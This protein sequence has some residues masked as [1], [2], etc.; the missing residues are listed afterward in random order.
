MNKRAAGIGYGFILGAGIGLV[1]GV[2]TRNLWIW[3][4]GGAVVGLLIG[5]LVSTFF[6]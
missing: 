1:I 3:T 6:D 2:I 5:W 4:A